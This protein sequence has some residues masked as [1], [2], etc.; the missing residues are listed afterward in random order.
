MNTKFLVVVTP[1]SIYHISLCPSFVYLRSLQTRKGEVVVLVCVESL[2]TL[3]D[4]LTRDQ[5]NFCETASLINSF[6]W[7]GVKYIGLPVLGSS[8]VH[9]EA[10]AKLN[11]EYIKIYLTLFQKYQT[12]KI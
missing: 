4:E 2:Q 8:L 7:S 5:S 10:K 3:F 9:M 12:C 11:V 1:L 6:S